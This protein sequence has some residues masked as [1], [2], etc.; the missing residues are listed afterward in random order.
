MTWHRGS[1]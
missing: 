1:I